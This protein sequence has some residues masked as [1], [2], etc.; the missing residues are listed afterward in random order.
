M[1]DDM[2]RAQAQEAFDREVA[3]QNT[4]AR[5]AAAMVPRNPGVDRRCVDCPRQIEE[6]RWVAL[7]G[8]TSR[9]ISC[10]QLY[11]RKVRGLS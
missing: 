1:T 8:C 10:A 11:E 5:I 4:A 3:L 2:D 9:C 6:E 7:R